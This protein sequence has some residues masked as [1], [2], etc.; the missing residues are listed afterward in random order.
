VPDEAETTDL[1]AIVADL[2]R[3]VRALED[4]REIRAVLSR[5]GFNADLG[6]ADAYVGLFTADGV[7]DL[8]PD[9]IQP[10]RWAGSE[11]LR[12]LITTDPHKQIEGHCQHWMQGLPMI[13]Y[14]DGDRAVAEGDS[15]TVVRGADG[16]FAVLMASYN[17]WTLVRT[18]QG[19]KI[20]E[21]I[22]RPAGSAGQ[23]EVFT[24]TVR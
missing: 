13:V 1:R 24:T 21:C 20:S 15:M 17:R 23:H 3:R 5:Y 8:D 4:E 10:S 12:T 18:G 7:M 6:R 14:V 9:V 11:Q 19:W 22:R 16:S 2:Q